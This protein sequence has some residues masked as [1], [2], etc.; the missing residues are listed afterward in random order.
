MGDGSECTNKILTLDSA[1]GT[2]EGKCHNPKGKQEM[3]FERALKME[4]SRIRRLFADQ[5][6]PR[7]FVEITAEGACDHGDVAITFRIGE[8]QY[9]DHVSGG[10]VRQCVREYFR[11]KGW[12]RENDPIMISYVPETPEED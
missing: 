1:G 9:G 6:A 5:N 10:D 11:R 2:E 7:I 3:S 12:K 4:V 8:G